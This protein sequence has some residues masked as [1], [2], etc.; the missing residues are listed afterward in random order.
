MQN[1]I[2]V[3]MDVQTT[4]FEKSP[5]TNSN[6]NNNSNE[7]TKRLNKKLVFNP[8]TPKLYI[9]MSN[10]SRLV[11]FKIAETI[12]IKPRKNLSISLVFLALIIFII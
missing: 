11:I 1:A 7:I 9:Y 12:K 4:F 3:T 8:N 5:K 10:V 6:P 2:N